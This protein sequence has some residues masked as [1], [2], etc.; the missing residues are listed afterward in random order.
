[1]Y[2]ARTFHML[3]T[4]SKRPA[5]EEMYGRFPAKEVPSNKTIR[6]IWTVSSSGMPTI[7]GEAEM[8]VVRASQ[9]QLV[10]YSSSSQ[11]TLTSW[12]SIARRRKSLLASLFPGR[13]RHK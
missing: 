9:S 3:S 1:M 2:V 6:D 11:V 13:K 12:D 10:S 5:M 8:D 4:W 7:S